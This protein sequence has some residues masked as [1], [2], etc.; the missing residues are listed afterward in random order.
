MAN[1]REC[2][3]VRDKYMRFL[4]IAAKSKY[5]NTV[6]IHIATGGDAMLGYYPIRRA[7]H[8]AQRLQEFHTVIWSFYSV[9]DTT[10]GHSVSIVSRMLFTFKNLVTVRKPIITYVL[11]VLFMDF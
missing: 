1:Y 3:L 5:L 2:G 9:M 7:S 6:N 10:F 8:L 11:L 4:V